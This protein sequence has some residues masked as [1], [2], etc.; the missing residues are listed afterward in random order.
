M[1]Q[2]IAMGLMAK[3]SPAKHKSAGFSAAMGTRSADTAVRAKDLMART[4][5]DEGGRIGL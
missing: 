4:L 1:G 2:W 5:S 3:G